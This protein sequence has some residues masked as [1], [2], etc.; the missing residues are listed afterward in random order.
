MALLVFRFISGKAKRLSL[1]V[2]WLVAGGEGGSVV[3]FGSLAP[4]AANFKVPAMT[5]YRTWLVSFLIYWCSCFGQHRVAAKPR[6]C[7]VCC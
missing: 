4:L 7:G 6:K 5:L 1:P 2:C 3:H